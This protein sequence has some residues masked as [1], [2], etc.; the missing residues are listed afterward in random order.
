MTARIQDGNGWYEIPDNPL[1]RVGVFDYKG[2][3]IGLTGVDADKIFQVYRPAEE[4]ASPETINSFR[5]VPL[6]DDH[7]MLGKSTPNAIPV[8]QK[9]AHG[10]IGDKV[11]FDQNE[12]MIKGNLKV[13]SNS[14]QA[15]I[16]NGKVDLSLG[17]KC[18][19]E[20]C[21]GEFN[22]LPF[23]FIQRDIR[24]N[25]V[26]NVNDGRMGDAVSVMDTITFDAK[27]L[28]KMP[29]S[30]KKR[31][32][33]AHSGLQKLLVARYIG[34]QNI[35]GVVVP[36]MDADEETAVASEPSLSD[37][38]D[39]LSDVL[40]QIATINEAMASGLM[41]GA[42]E[43]DGD[44]PEMDA[45]GNPV[46]D[47]EGKPVMKK[48]A[49]PVDPAANPANPTADKAPVMDKATMDA[50]IA[51]ATKPLLAQ[52][53][54]MKTSAPTAASLAADISKRDNLARQLSHFVGTFDH[55]EMS[56]VD[57]AKYAVDKLKIPTMDGQE[58]NSVSAW[59]HGRPVPKPVY[60]GV[61]T[62]DSGENKSSVLEYLK[63]KVAA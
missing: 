28:V 31:N 6:I 14:Q 54:A 51:A 48:K 55:S 60:G 47:A 44:E 27:D 33:K 61:A 43:P 40:P 17:Y 19:Y 21:V 1:S 30:L 49:P 41:A 50:A 13:W 29:D 45:A 9:G 39:L 52:I 12:G 32:P 18:K 46:M 24:G 5:L 22:G 38:A 56:L 2:S 16:N 59:L 8:E 25:H 35:K 34:K 37:V 15:K 62:V 36:T 53:E 23:Q 7:I 63:P 11:W 42:G 20:P 4:L 10:V 57:V 58:I 3:S 26:A